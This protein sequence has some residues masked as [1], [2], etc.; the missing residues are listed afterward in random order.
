[1]ASEGSEV[2]DST[3]DLANLL[4]CSVT[5]AVELFPDAWMEPP[6]FQFELF[7]PDP[8]TEHHWELGFILSVSYL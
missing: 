6:V 2:G 7:V 8:V 5:T 1:M 3:I 4:E